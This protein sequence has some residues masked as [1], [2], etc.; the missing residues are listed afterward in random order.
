VAIILFQDQNIFPLAR[1]VIVYGTPAI[2]AAIAI[3]MVSR[4]P[5]KRFYRILGRQPFHQVLILILVMALVLAWK[6]PMLLLLT[7]GY[8]LSGPIQYLIR[9]L[10][11]RARPVATPATLTPAA[12]QTRPTDKGH[13][14]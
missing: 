1:N 5:Y 2:T 11:D 10:R 7:V 12:P 4:I 3:L 13:A 9:I 6:A 14:V 8:G